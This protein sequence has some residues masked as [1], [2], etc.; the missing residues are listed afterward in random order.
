MEQPK[1]RSSLRL[2]VGAPFHRLKKYIYWYFSS[3]NFSSE[4]S[5]TILENKIFSHQTPLLRQLKNV[6]MQWQHNKIVNLKLATAKINHLLIKPGQ[7]FSFWRQIGEPLAR[8]GYQPGMILDHGQIK[9]ATGG[10]LCQLSNL[11]F[12]M[13]VHTPLTI[14]E[15]WRHDYDVFPDSNRQQPF[16]SGATCCYPNIDLQ[17]QNTTTQTFQLYFQITADYL[18]GSYFSDQPVIYDYKIIEKDHLIKKEWWGGYSRSN[19]LYRQIFIPPATLPVSEE[20]LVSNQAIMMY[21]P[22]LKSPPSFLC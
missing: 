15:R 7:V 8:F 9:V 13:T 3:N 2:A 17:I 10:G 12:W 19:K 18:I 16:G 20:F 22:L 14:I 5:N 4:Q 21:N 1:N 6:D 11:L